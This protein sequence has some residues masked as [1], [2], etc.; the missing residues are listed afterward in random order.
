MSENRERATNEEWNEEWKELGVI[1]HM[2]N[3]AFNSIF[4]EE[5]Q[6]LPS[7]SPCTPLPPSSGYV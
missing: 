2:V 3:E 4:R 6:R 5:Q 7:S 1:L